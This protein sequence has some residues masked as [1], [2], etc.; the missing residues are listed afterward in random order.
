MAASPKVSVIIPFF[1]RR[2]WLAEAV[3]SVLRQ[4]YENYEIIVINDG[5]TE[6]LT[7]FRQAF[8]KKVRWIDQENAGPGAAR[9]RGI[10]IAEGEYIAFLDS[11]DLWLEEKLAKQVSLMV[12]T[13]A[14]WSHTSYSLFREREAE[15]VVKI[16]DVSRFAG[17][18]YPQCLA[19]SPVATP[20]VMI[21]SSYLKEYPW[22]RFSEQMRWG[23]DGYLW[24]K[25]AT[26]NP[27]FALPEVVT[28]V[29]IR[30]GRTAGRARASLYTKANLWADIRQN[31]EPLSPEKKIG[32]VIQGAYILC[33]YGNMVVTSIEMRKFFNA[34]IMEYISIII[35]FLPYMT[36]KYYYW[37]HRIKHLLVWYNQHQGS[38]K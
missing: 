4:T 31:H 32:I 2:D 5:S 23:Q 1:S 36:L 15:P 27:L 28:K 8:G 14:V 30:P 21:K 35:Y 18:V 9:N 12:E 22:I 16:I 20:C 17:M 26:A 24:M 7:S 3:D 29:R 11:D 37:A 19:S 13:G 6:D 33:F 10:E 34:R 38:G 25:L